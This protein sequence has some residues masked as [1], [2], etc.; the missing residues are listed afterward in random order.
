M[1]R[2][3]DRRLVLATVVVVVVTMA[4]GTIAAQ[5]HHIRGAVDYEG[6]A[7]IPEGQVKIF[8]EDPAIQNKALNSTAKTHVTSD[9]AS[10]TLDFSLS[11]PASSAG[12]SPTLQIVARLERMDGWLLARGS[13][14]LSA[15]SPVHITLNTALY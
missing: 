11:L 4:A 9:G 5:S 1:K 3:A 13:A 7:V 6:G 2:S 15:G 10:K 14:K 8:L 12:S